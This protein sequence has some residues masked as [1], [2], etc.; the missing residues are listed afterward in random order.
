MVENDKKVYNNEQ[1]MGGLLPHH[2]ENF[3]SVVHTFAC[4]RTNIIR[5][6]IIII[7]KKPK[8]NFHNL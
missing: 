1:Q 3:F 5:G 4:I 6:W 8:E 2:T 7:K